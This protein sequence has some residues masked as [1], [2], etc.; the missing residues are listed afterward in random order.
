MDNRPSPYAWRRWLEQ[1]AGRLLLFARQQTRTDTDAEDLLQESLV[2]AWQRIGAD[3]LPP[4]PLVIATLRRRAI[5]RARRDD[6]RRQ[7]EEAS[8]P[9][10][11]AWFDTATADAETRELVTAGLR[12]LPEIYREVVTLKIWGELTFAEIAEALAIPANTA[13]SRYRYGL[14]MLRKELKDEHVRTTS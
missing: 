11:A 10:D 9:G 1:H 13:A 2:E 4:V 7:R 3:E 6:R 5:D 8:S 12:K 14:E